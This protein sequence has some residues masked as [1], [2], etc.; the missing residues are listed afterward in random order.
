MEKLYK[1][2]DIIRA[3]DKHTKDTPK[4]LV[5][6]E[7]ITIILEELQNKQIQLEDNLISRENAI[8]AIC[9]NCHI[10]TPATCITRLHDSKWC[11]EVYTLMHL[12][13]P[14]ETTRQ[15][16]KNCQEFDCYG[17]EWRELY[18]RLN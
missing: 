11:P 12:P 15:Q 9:N 8:E 1:E 5:L 2:S 16:C 4:G 13:S 14:Q 3:I 18:E 17:C 6:D 10:D 7:D